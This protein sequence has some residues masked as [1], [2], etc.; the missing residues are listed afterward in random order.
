MEFFLSKEVI[1]TNLGGVRGV[2]AFACFFLKPVDSKLYPWNETRTL[3]LPL[4]LLVS[5]L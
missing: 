4:S 5:L 2:A 1:L 3:V